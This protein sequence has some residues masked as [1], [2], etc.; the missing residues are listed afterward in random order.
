MSDD[1]ANRSDARPSELLA[2]PEGARRLTTIGM[3]QKEPGLCACGQHADPD[4]HAE[5]H[6]HGEPPAQAEPHAHAGPARHGD[7]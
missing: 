3:A 7:A 6:T 5:P 4:A 1:Q 2:M